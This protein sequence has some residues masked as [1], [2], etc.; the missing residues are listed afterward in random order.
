MYNEIVD[1][2]SKRVP[3]KNA[4]GFTFVQADGKRKYTALKSEGN[5]TSYTTEI[6]VRQLDDGLFDPDNFYCSPGE[7]DITAINPED[8]TDYVLDN[9]Y[10]PEDSYIT[11]SIGRAQLDFFKNR[12]FQ[13][14]KY[15]K[16]DESKGIPNVTG[17][18]LDLEARPEFSEACDEG[19]VC[20]MPNCVEYY[21]VTADLAYDEAF[22]IAEEYGEET[23]KREI[24]DLMGKTID[25]VSAGAEVIPKGLYFIKDNKIYYLTADEYHHIYDNSGY[26]RKDLFELI[27]TP[28]F[29]QLDS[30]LIKNTKQALFTMNTVDKAF[31]ALGEK[32]YFDL[33]TITDYGITPQDFLS[34]L[35]SND[36]QAFELLA[37]ILKNQ[38]NV[39]RR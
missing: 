3:N 13:I 1:G 35:L 19:I 20:D 14:D 5:E 38:A 25:K 15:I 23:F 29:Y 24:D 8:L 28:G 34:R 2:L 10:R 30:G 17:I 6:L 11:F 16:I 7:S 26:N 12:D 36:S 32:I 21:N 27:E 39:P 9:F 33:T 31:G 4:S 18:V 22:D 37:N